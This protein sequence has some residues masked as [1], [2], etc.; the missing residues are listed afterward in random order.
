M[1]CTFILFLFFH[2]HNAAS[3]APHDSHFFIEKKTIMI[4]MHNS[5]HFIDHAHVYPIPI[6]P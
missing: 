6:F 4:S 2:N 3:I 5:L 1:M